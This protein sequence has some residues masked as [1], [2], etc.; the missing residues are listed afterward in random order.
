[1]GVCKDNKN[2]L[3]WVAQELKKEYEVLDNICEEDCDVIICMSISQ[4]YRVNQLRAKYPK[5]KVITYNWDWYPW[6]DNNLMPEREYISLMKDSAEVWS[7]SENAREMLKL[8]T[9]IDSVPI[10][11]YIVPEEWG[12]T[13]DKNYAVMASR[14]TWYK[15]FNWF[16]SACGELGIPY[17]TYH[18]R[19]NSREDYI[20]GVS[21]CSMLVS[22][23]LYEGFGLTPIEGAYNGKPIVLADTDIF[24]ELW[25]LKAYF[26]DP[27]NYTSFKNTMK[28]AWE[29]RKFNNN[30]K[31]VEENF[32]PQRMAQRIH[33]RLNNIL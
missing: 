18:P 12:K 23:S 10:Y 25:N 31:Y 17:K 26:F 28:E 22:P 24:R 21:N 8:S 11:G 2:F 29:E 30:R 27:H 20:K 3:W 14:D 16:E 7:A 15:R 13:S 9:G 1:M 6:V 19:Y 32:L 5:I 33:D 4:L